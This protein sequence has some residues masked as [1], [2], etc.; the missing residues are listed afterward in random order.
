VIK[1]LEF[2]CLESVLLRQSWLFPILAAKGALRHESAHSG[3]A[4][5][6][7]TYRA[8]FVRKIGKKSL[9]DLARAKRIP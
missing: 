8:D 9:F 6:K 4:L 3:V 1:L 2:S 7:P 5:E